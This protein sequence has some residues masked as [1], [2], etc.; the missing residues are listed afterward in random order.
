MLLFELWVPILTNPA[1]TEVLETP[2]M[3]LY[4]LDSDQA[5]STQTGIF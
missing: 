4:A 5:F 3:F 1:E 2:G